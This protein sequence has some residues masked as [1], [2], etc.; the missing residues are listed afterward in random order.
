MARSRMSI[1]I[2]LLP[3]A[4]HSRNVAEHFIFGVRRIVPAKSIA[5]RDQSDQ[6]PFFGFTHQPMR[7]K[8]PL[9]GEEHNFSAAGAPGRPATNNEG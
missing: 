6:S 4:D 3:A 7:V 1:Q 9:S 8:T 2:D 5:A